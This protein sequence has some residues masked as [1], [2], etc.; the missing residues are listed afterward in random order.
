MPVEDICVESCNSIEVE[1]VV[2]CAGWILSG[3]GARRGVVE[4]ETSWLAGILS[5][6]SVG[7]LSRCVDVISGV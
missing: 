5:S 3:S 1:L 2:G 6:A 4:V 7:S